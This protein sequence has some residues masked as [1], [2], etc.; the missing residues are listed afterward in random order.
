M[1][2]YTLDRDL[3]EDSLRFY[4]GE[5]ERKRK[6][7]EKAQLQDGIEPATYLYHEVCF[8]QL[9][10]SITVLQLLP[11]IVNT[12]RTR[13]GNQLVLRKQGYLRKMLFSVTTF[14]SLTIEIFLCANQFSSS[15]SSPSSGF[16]AD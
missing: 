8:P 11:K 14:D 3:I 5:L 12:W 1:Y 7:V 15:S 16:S 10:R 2:R 4:E 13:G 9:L 6:E